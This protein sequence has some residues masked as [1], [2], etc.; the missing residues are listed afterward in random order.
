MEAI[1]KLGTPSNMIL[2]IQKRRL[3]FGKEIPPNFA[4]QILQKTAR[5]TA[6]LFQEWRIKTILSA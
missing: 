4:A 3:S 1:F 6:N 2:A 5:P